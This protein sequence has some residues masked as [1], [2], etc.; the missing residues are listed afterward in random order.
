MDSLIYSLITTM[1]RA[2][3]ALAAVSAASSVPSSEN[4]SVEKMTVDLASSE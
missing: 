1:F 3:C 2:Y 4:K